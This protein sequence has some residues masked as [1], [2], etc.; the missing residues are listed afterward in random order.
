MI[1][2]IIISLCSIWSNYGPKV[3]QFST[4]SWVNY[5]PSTTDKTVKTIATTYPTNDYV[6][7]VETQMSAGNVP[8]GP[9]A[10]CNFRLTTNRLTTNGMFGTYPCPYSDTVTYSVVLKNG[11]AYLAG[12]V[13]PYGIYQLSLVEQCTGIDSKYDHRPPPLLPILR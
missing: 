11:L 4:G 12:Y 5:C 6:I 13:G 7:K 8:G 1:R 10:L 2:Y 3:Y 9:L